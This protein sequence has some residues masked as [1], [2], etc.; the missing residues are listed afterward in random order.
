[1]EIWNWTGSKEHFGS[2]VWWPATLE[3]G[4]LVESRDRVV[5]IDWSLVGKEVTLQIRICPEITII[6][7]ENG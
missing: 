7:H 5:E 6:S 2:L 3:N 1:M 4:N